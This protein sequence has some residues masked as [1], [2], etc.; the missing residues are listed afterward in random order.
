MIENVLFSLKQCTAKYVALCEGDDY[1]TDPFKL[2]K[3][4]D[5]LEAHQEYVGC[6]HNTEE[7]YEEGNK[8]SF[9]YCQFP[10]AQNVSFAELAYSNLIPTCSALFR[11]N[12]FEGF[13]EWY[14]QL[15][16]GDW[17]LHLLN[18][19]FG[20]FWYLP[21]VMAVHRLH[22]NSTW[23]LQDHQMNVNYVLDAYD[24]MIKGYA[25]DDKLCNYLKLGKQ[26]FLSR[27]NGGQRIEIK[28][29]S[30]GQRV[31]NRIKRLLIGNG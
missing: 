31:K 8:A 3:Q 28:K 13:P 24:S 25:N 9:L 20:D 29:S 19:Q 2:Q 26:S 27:N 14:H 1:W 21:Q 12:L 6:F 18:A 17:P 11:N 23:M 30:I 7:R 16:M 5:F 4:V 10:F 22:I 15:K